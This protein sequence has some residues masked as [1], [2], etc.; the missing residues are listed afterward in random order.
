MLQAG[1]LAESLFRVFDA[2][3][4]GNLDFFE[5][6]QANS[7]KNLNTPEDKLGWMFD[8]FDA[9]DGGTVDRDEITDIVV[10]L[11]RLGGIEEDEDLLAACVFDVIEAVDQ[12]G[13][14][15][16][17]KDEFVKNAMNC[18]FIYNMLKSKRS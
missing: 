16:I 1:L 4:S 18:K 6:V 2:D 11:F 12:E 10:G 17:S 14:G 15:D 3:K 7:V 9:D 13:D 5:F 8:A